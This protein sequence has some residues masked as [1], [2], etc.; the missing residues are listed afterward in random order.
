MLIIISFSFLNNNCYKGRLIRII[1]NKLIAKGIF[2]TNM[3]TNNRKIKKSLASN[4]IYQKYDRV[5]IGSNI[6]VGKGK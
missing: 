4:D 3:E 2:Y 5:V 6:L 1:Y